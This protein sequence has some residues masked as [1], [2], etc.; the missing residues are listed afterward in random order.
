MISEYLKKSDDIS[1]VAADDVTE[2]LRAKR[3][4]EASSLTPEENNR[5]SPRSVAERAQ[6]IRNER[7][8]K[9]A[10]ALDEVERHLNL[11][12]AAGGRD[13]ADALRSKLPREDQEELKQRPWMPERD[14]E[15][16]FDREMRDA[17]RRVLE[18]IARRTERN[19]TLSPEQSQRLMRETQSADEPEKPFKE[20]GD[21]ISLG[22]GA[23]QT[24]G[25][26]QHEARI[27]RD[28]LE[29]R[30]V[31]KKKK[32]GEDEAASADRVPVSFRSRVERYFRKLA[33]Q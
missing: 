14:A 19:R 4:E 3:L 2:A 12:E 26:G 16:F 27:A 23:Y 30:D 11:L 25:I 24:G 5:L 20:S 13:V 18:S 9:L 1:A 28:Q 22:R 10:D 33:D 15:P 32:D 7:R 6:R 21:G 17:G 29:V 8:E 31:I